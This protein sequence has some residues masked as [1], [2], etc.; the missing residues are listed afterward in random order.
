MRDLID[1][2]EGM[3]VRYGI[4]RREHVAKRY[5]EQRPEND[6]RFWKGMSEQRM[7][8]LVGDDPLENY[9]RAAKAGRDS[10]AVRMAPIKAI[11]SHFITGEDHPRG[12]HVWDSNQ[13]NGL[14]DLYDG[15]VMIFQVNFAFRKG[16]FTQA[17]KG[18][19]GP[20][21]REMAPVWALG[22]WR[23]F[24][25][26]FNA[27]PNAF[28]VAPWLPEVAPVAGKEAKLTAI[29]QRI[30]GKRYHKVNDSAREVKDQQAMERFQKAI[31][32]VLSQM[33]FE[34]PPYF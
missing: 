33:N 26:E 24:E 3:P 13:R 9:P 21:L 5:A 4:R 30:V 14:T 18:E 27:H 11:K 20:E 17:A 22:A 8:G 7:A 1:I 19:L 31:L 16:V 23:V 25:R 2:V 10:K 28:F 29:K 32:L 6:P 34:P 12:G 15:E